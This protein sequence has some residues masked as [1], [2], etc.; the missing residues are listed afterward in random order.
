MEAALGLKLFYRQ[1][2]GMELTEEGRALLAY[3]KQSFALLDAAQ[4]HARELKQLA[5]GEVRI[6]ASDSLIKHLLLP[7]LDAFR[8]QY[9]AVRLR[10]SRGNTPDMTRR[11]KEGAIDLAIVHLPVSDPQ[12]ALQPLAT[13]EDCFVVGA[14]NADPD[15]APMSA[16]QVAALPLL[17]LSP[18]SSTRVYAEQWFAARGLT[19]K[20]DME[21]GSIDLLAE[22]A[23][24]GFGAALITRSF[25]LE[26][27][28]SGTLVELPLLEPLPPRTVG[29]AIRRDAPLSLA[30]EH[31]VRMLRAS[32]ADE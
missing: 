23:R 10:L 28:R 5:A 22:F 11:L 12:L 31:F 2:K 15:R 30:A 32:P 20:P 17:L 1:A 8:R 21:L 29:L 19:V 13:L 3:V 25:V 27:L 26:E 9:P 18:G 6:G 24:L 14:S 16:Q 7:H 4:Q